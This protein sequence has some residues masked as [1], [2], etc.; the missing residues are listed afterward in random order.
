MDIV[1]DNLY[2]EVAVKCEYFGSL[3]CLSESHKSLFFQYFI[4][5][6]G[7]QEQ[8]EEIGRVLLKGV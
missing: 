3:I 7:T 6:F 4:L 8:P 1:V 5:T 2:S